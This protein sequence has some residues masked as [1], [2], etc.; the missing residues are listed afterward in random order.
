MEKIVPKITGHN[1][2]WL[3]TNDI[4]MNLKRNCEIYYVKHHA[5]IVSF[6][7]LVACF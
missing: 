6:L 7:F 1:F 3:S 2:V 5:V 4:K